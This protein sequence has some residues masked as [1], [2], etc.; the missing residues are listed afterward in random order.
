M[1]AK[2]EEAGT[3]IKALV[4]SSLR[5]EYLS[6]EHLVTYNTSNLVPMLDRKQLQLILQLVDDLAV[7]AKKFSTGYPSEYVLH[8]P[9]L[10][11]LFTDCMKEW[12][13]GAPRCCQLISMMQSW[14]FTQP[15]CWATRRRILQA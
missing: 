7:E 8:K 4:C 15:C 10:V 11:C 1:Y 12:S 5:G 13:R 3:A 6:K 9:E 2:P 14:S